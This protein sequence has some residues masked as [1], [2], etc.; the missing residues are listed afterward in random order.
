MERVHFDELELDG[1]QVLQKDGAP[2]TGTAFETSPSGHVVCEVSFVSGLQEGAAK[3][4]FPSG[5]VELEENYLNGAKLGVCSKWYEDGRKRAREVFEYSILVESEEWDE[6]GN[7]IGQ[8]RIPPES[9]QF[10]T[11]ERLRAAYGRHAPS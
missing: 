1:H 6:Q 4:F 7:R 8:Y 9:P 2:F 3:E 10:R 5:R 11:L